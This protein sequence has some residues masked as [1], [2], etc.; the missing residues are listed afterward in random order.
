MAGLEATSLLILIIIVVLGCGSSQGA[1][2]PPRTFIGQIMV[3]GNEP[4]TRLAVQVEHTKVYLI[5]C[6]NNTKEFLLGNQGRIVELIYNEIRETQ[7]G[8]ELNV[9]SASISPN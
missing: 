9:L 4:F 1:F 2:D 3:V 8:E 6:N 7:Q 5:A